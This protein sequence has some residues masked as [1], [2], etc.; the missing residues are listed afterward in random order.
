MQRRF[1]TLNIASDPK[2]DL[3]Q[4]EGATIEVEWQNPIDPAT[5]A[6]RDPCP[7]IL[8][9]MSRQRYRPM[10]LKETKLVISP[11]WLARTE[12]KKTSGDV[13]NKSD[14]RLDRIQHP[15][16]LRRHDDL[17]R[18]HAPLAGLEPVLV[19]ESHAC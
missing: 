10:I 14:D 4:T 5:P 8:T 2:G 19:R 16:L 15:R 18:N 1:Q 7:V 11:S 17:R 12:L 9:P 13:A 3:R 6:V